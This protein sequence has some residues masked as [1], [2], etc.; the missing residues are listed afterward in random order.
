[1]TDVS[2]SELIYGDTGY[3]CTSF[4]KLEYQ[5]M[6]IERK[7]AYAPATVSNICV[8]FDAVSYT[9]LD[10]YKR[11]THSLYQECTGNRIS[12]FVE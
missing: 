9:H 5:Y 11:Q 7:K 1:M 3:I 10:V 2:Q 4:Y 6:A 8:G 12:C